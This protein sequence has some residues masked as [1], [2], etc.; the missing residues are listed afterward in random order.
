MC[1]KLDNY[2]KILSCCLCN[3]KVHPKC[4][5]QKL[6]NVNKIDNRYE[7][8]FC[9][10]CKENILPFQKNFNAQPNTI[11]TVNNN[12]NLFL[13]SIN[14][15]NKTNNLK[16]DDD[17][18]SENPIINCEYVDIE[19]FNHQERKSNLSLFHLNIASLSK[20]KDELETLLNSMHFKFDIL[21]ISESKLKKG[22]DPNFD[23]NI[24]GYNHFS[25]STES[26]NGGTLLYISDSLKYKPRKDLENILYKSK[27]LESTFVEIVNP[28]K[29]NIIVGCVYK[30]PVMDINEF[31]INYV[32]PLLQKI[33][34]ED[35][36]IFL[37]VDF[38]IELLK[39]NDNKKVSNFLD[40][41]S[42]YLFTPHVVIPSRINLNNPNQTFSR[43]LIDNIY[44][45]C[46][47]FSEGVSGNLT[48]SIS[49]HLAQFLIIP[50]DYCRKS[51]SI[52]SFKR[53]TK[54]FDKENFILDIFDTNWNELI[55]IENKDPNLSFD[56]FEN[57]I[58]EIIDKYMPLRKLSKGEIKLRN[59]PWITKGI[60][61]SIKQRD[62][63]HK[64][65]VKSKSDSK[66][67]EYNLQYKILR[68][69]IVNLIRISKKNHFQKYFQNNKN[70][71]RNTWKG[72]KNI[73]SF[74]SKN[75]KSSPP[76][77]II[78]DNDL[79]TDTVEVAEHFNDH[80][81]T[82]ADKLQE[83]IY[84][85]GQNFRNY[86]DKRN[87][88]TMFIYQTDAIEVSKIISSLNVTKAVGPHSIPSV[89]LKLI[90]PI[91]AEPIAKII[92]LSFTTGIYLENLKISKVIPIFKD[93]GSKLDINNY[94]PI[95]L[96]SN[97]N[98]VLEKLMHKRLSSFLSKHKCLYDLQ[99]GFRKK[100]STTHTLMYLT[101]TVRKAIDN[102]NFACSIFIDLQKAFDT[103]DHDVLLYKLDHY[104]IRGITNDWFKSYLKNRKQFVSING[105]NS[106]EK[107]VAYGVPQG[108]VLGPLLFL[109]Y[110]NDLHKA[111]NHCTALHFADDTVLIHENKSLKQMQKYV[112]IDL[113]NINNW[114]KANKISLNTSKTEMLLF[115]GH[116][117][118][119]N[120]NLKIKL[121]GRIIHP[122]DVV[123]YLGI[124][125][126]SHLNWNYHTNITVTK[127][128]RA[129]G[130]LA[131]IRHYVSKKTLRQIYFSIFSP[132]LMY[133][134]LIWGQIVNSNVK[135]IIRQQNK[136]M[137]II[138]FANFDAP[139]D[140]LY[141][142]SKIVKFSTSI[143]YQNLLFVY[144]NLQNKSP[145]VLHKVFNFV[146]IT[147][148]Y[149]TRISDR[150][151]SLPKVRTTTYGLNSMEYKCIALW[152]RLVSKF[153]KSNLNDL[154]KNEITN[155]IK[156]CLNI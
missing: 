39:I 120:Y 154:N 22:T 79:L 148:N 122:S 84:N 128:S 67:L 129:V 87:D 107:F 62:K 140:A 132:H 45:N 155:Y 100:H 113:K 11:P 50:I 72:I 86:L 7:Y 35:K 78:I 51:E 69:T 13:K 29:K 46:L 64:K 133:G 26:N 44:S 5:K 2:K 17:I 25:T 115:R 42:S 153:N 91:I 136:A 41:I 80:F 73:I 12:I 144:N 61:V 24:K 152:N 23:I 16:D 111:L 119:I 55:Q 118:K 9:F 15:I 4:N 145:L 112:N 74:N 1:K 28:G 98:K 58:M 83:K 117:K 96:L 71:I 151:L 33:M 135:R 104:G 123:K 77:S 93:K 125:I 138:N 63:I 156:I 3:C 121:N 124:Y 108:S 141:S 137:R 114:L 18:N 57:K 94:R 53:D 88:N 130:M 126:D 99:F 47:N 116:R 131:K 8:S 43:T 75:N 134:S 48:I 81:T 147:H 59:K 10:N 30:H 70:N 6:S 90:I 34:R 40:I 37:M 60:R 49:D 65:M 68:N 14:E 142:I 103:V 38:N 127:L 66:K 143:E 139:S 56:T 105:L 110:I 32:E 149:N 146:F 150:M 52:N 20:H 82:I 27:Q 85:S 54:N 97:I 89:I 19:S 21:G 31:N 36:K 109:I 95:S 76:T 101:E 102:D 92:N 106:G